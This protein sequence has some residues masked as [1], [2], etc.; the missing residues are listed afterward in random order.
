MTIY[1]IHD[2]ASQVER[3]R[4]RAWCSL[5]LFSLQKQMLRGLAQ[6]MLLI[7]SLLAYGQASAACNLSFSTTVGGQVTQSGSE[8]KYTF[9]ATD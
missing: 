4:Y 7:F 2:P 6:L 8:Y 9:S 1:P 5:L 3:M